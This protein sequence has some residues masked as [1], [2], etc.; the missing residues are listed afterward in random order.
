MF[1]GEPGVNTVAHP[2]MSLVEGMNFFL[3]LVD[4]TFRRDPY[5]HRPRINKLNSVKD[6]EQKNRG[7]YF[8]MD[9]ELEKGEK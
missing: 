2:P 9:T 3:K 4:I 6:Q 8:S 1:D 7:D 5:N